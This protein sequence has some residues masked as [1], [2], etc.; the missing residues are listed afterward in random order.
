M[1]DFTELYLAIDSTNSTNEKAKLLE[2]YFASADPR[3]AAWTVT[4]IAGERPKGTASTRVL[5]ELAQEVTN[6][7][8]WLLDECHGAVG[9]LSESIAL[10]TEAQDARDTRIASDEPLHGVMENRVLPLAGSDE[11]QK[12]RLIRETWR[13]FSGDERFVYHK[14]IRGGFRFGV[15]KRLLTRALASLTGLDRSIIAQRLAGRVQP[16][17]EFYE[18]LISPDTSTRDDALAPY[19]FFLA[20]QLDDPPE[21]L[22]P[23]DQWAAE[24]K[25]DGV[26]AQLIHRHAQTALWSRGE[27]VMTHQFPEIVSNA[28]ELDGCVLDGEILMWRGDRPEPF[29]VLQT[30]LNRNVSPTHQHRLFDDTPRAVFVAYDLLEH[31]GQ[32]VRDRPLHERRALLVSILTPVQNEAIRL[33]ETIDANDWDGLATIREESSSRGTEGLMLKRLDSTYGIGRTKG[34][35]DG[36]WWKWKVDPYTVDAVM[37]AAQLGSG[38]RASMF[39]DYTFSL[40]DESDQGERALVTFA[41]AYSGLTNTEIESIDRWVR[42]NTVGRAGPVRFVKPQRVFEIGFEGLRESSRHKSGIAVRFPRIH[43]LRDEKNPEEAD[44][45]ETLRSML[46]GANT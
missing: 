24:W 34:D 2:S 13:A 29:A 21:T 40:W 26:R 14:L 5:R 38:R 37:T 18:S 17:P 25:W 10:L 35:T 16:T 1:K 45:I 30:R 31:H 22:G 3:D 9:D 20:H 32:D 33:S 43:R 23:I 28:K 36:A 11:T 7:P 46:K 41:K 4:L 44:T 42:Q 39:T 15:Q 27:E 8:A 12:K 6:L 19:P